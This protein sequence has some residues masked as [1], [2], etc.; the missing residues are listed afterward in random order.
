MSKFLILPKNPKL[1]VVQPLYISFPS[2]NISEYILHSSI[3]FVK[4][5]I[6]YVNVF[7]GNLYT[8][9]YTYILL[10]LEW[11]AKV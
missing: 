2:S 7:N 4:S 3:S 9:W 6:L 1:H 11:I 5:L 8:P 10:R